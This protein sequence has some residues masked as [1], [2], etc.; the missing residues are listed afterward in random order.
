MEQNF[1]TSFMPKKPMIEERAVAARPVG[2][3]A[4]VSIF[5]FLTVILVTGG[6]YFYKNFTQT[7]INKKEAD[8]NK[9]KGR[10][11]PS[12]IV[13]LQTLDKRL[14]ASTEVLSNHIAITPVFKMLEAVTMKS[15][16]YTK[17]SYELGDEKATKITFKINGQATGYRSIAL[18]SDLFTKNKQLIDP[19]FSNLALDDKGNVLFELSFSVDPNFV[20]YKQTLKSESANPILTPSSAGFETQN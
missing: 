16:R 18:Q 1:Q 6:L 13:E 11:E 7:T 3:L 5:I 2:L 4:V 17:F 19:V 8:L 9:A 14:R 10:F 15:V 12:K 20:N